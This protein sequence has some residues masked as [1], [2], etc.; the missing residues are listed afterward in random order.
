MKLRLT[1]LNGSIAGNSYELESGHLLI[2]RS[3]NCSIK[4]DPFQENII[5][6][7]HAFVYSGAEGFYVRDNKSTNGTFLNGE[8]AA[9]DLL[10]S[11]DVIVL[12]KD[13]I[14][15]RVE[16]DGDELQSVE[17]EI[18][19]LPPTED[20]G[21]A[22]TAPSAAPMASFETLEKVQSDAMNVSQSMNRIGLSSPAVKLPPP[23]TAKYVAVVVMTALILLALLP[24]LLI[25]VGG[26]GP[27]PTVIATVT[28]FLPVVLYL[29]PLVWLDRYDPEPFW[30]L[31]LC[32]SWGGI[33]AVLASAIVN[34]IFTIVATMSTSSAIIG[35]IAGAVISAPFI[36]ELMKGAGLLAMLLF[37]RRHFDDI[38]DG[39]VFGGVIALGFAAV[40]NVL[41]Y[42]RGFLAEGFAG[43]A[44]MFVLRGVLSP[45]AHVTFTV[46]TGIGCGIARES[47]NWFV[48]ILMPLFG[49]GAAMTLH[50]IWNG[51][52]VF[53]V[54]AL[55]VTGS[56]AY[57]SAVGL[58]GDN[59]GICGFLIGYAIL[60][61]PVFLIF[62]GFSL[63]IMRR[64][65][66]T[67]REML[68][69]DVARGLV[70]QEHLDIATSL[71]K[72][73]FWPLGGI[74][75]GKFFKRRRYLQA[76][77]SLG[78]SYW[79]I[80]RATAAQ[81]HTASFQ[82]NPYLRSEVEKYSKLV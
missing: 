3:P 49:L 41:Y 65:S 5:S 75:S 31:L 46:M 35:Q 63:Y 56:S 43:L 26:L 19:D 25:I 9:N 74:T 66:R 15:L 42:G 34:D 44:V 29:A 10:V 82:Q 48:R 51:M 20:G 71:F 45:F 23:Q 55:E 11:G 8:P 67:L 69:I 1:V 27:I 59:L 38:L 7:Q 37:F 50:A 21:I 72:S 57:C 33:V 78:L 79:H 16:I 28:A 22:I 62:V 17:T 36:E 52:S 47:H 53:S 12:G 61:V 58:G 40:E 76:L 54:I 2:G 60:E 64:Q 13:G 70:P 6:S 81:G 24:V 30:L 4:F 32:F 68:A 14:K 80:Q 18:R 73:M 39:I 77:G